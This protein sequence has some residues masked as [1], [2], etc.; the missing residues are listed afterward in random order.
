MY[1]VPPGD[2]PIAVNKC[3]IYIY[4]YIYIYYSAKNWRISQSAGNYFCD[5]F[6]KLR[7][8]TIS[9]V[10]ADRLSGWKSSAPNGRIFMKFDA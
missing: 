10:M 4:I 6:A 9:L 7:K 3:I 2:N 5:A 1:C 8:G